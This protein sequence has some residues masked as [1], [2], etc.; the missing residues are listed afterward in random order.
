MAEMQD[1]MLADTILKLNKALFNVDSLEDFL[2]QIREPLRKAIF[3]DWSCFFLAGNFDSPPAMI[4]K[5]T[6]HFSWEKIHPMITAEDM[7]ASIL[8]RALPGEIFL[9]QNMTGTG[10]E[11][12][13]HTLELIYAKSGYRFSQH[14]ILAVINGFRLFMSMFRRDKPFNLDS[15]RALNL[16]VPTLTTCAQSLLSIR[17]SGSERILL[18]GLKITPDFK[19]ILLDNNLEATGLPE[20]TREFLIE[21]FHGPFVRELPELLRKWLDTFLKTDC[22]LKNKSEENTVFYSDEGSIVC[23]LNF[24]EDSSGSSKYL[25]VLEHQ[26]GTDD[27]THLEGLGLT[28][29]EVRILAN[30][31]AGKTNMQIGENLGIKEITVRKHLQNIG[32]K[33]HATGRAE[34]LAKA[35]EAREILPGRKSLSTT[36]KDLTFFKRIPEYSPDDDTCTRTIIDLSQK[37]NTLRNFDEIPELLKCVLAKHMSFDW[38]AVYCMTSSNEIEKI[39]VSPGLPFDW[40]KLYP[41]IRNFMSWIPAVRKGMTGEIFLTQDL[42]NPDN[43]QDLFTKTVMEAATGVFYSLIMPVAK[44]SG[45]RAFLGLYRNDSECPY[46]HDDVTV[47]DKLSPIIMLW[48]QNVLR[49][50]ESI[51]DYTGNSI[52]LERKHV[53]AMLFDEHLCDAMWTKDAM[54]LLI[55]QVGPYWR[56]D[57]L[58]S[59]RDWIKKKKLMQTGKKPSRQL[60]DPLVFN[61]YNLECHAYPLDSHILVKFTSR[62]QEPFLMLNKSGLTERQVQILSYLRLGYTNRQISA[63]LNIAEVTVK[64]HMER[65]GSKLEVHGRVAILCRAEEIR[66]SMV[67]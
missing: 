38:A 47:M 52:M 41:A 53:R 66:Q 55:S 56:R 11:G 14:V 64:K 28:R 39:I 8:F 35:I 50:M 25:A 12:D 37:I 58:P 63:A 20:S 61:K 59:L 34:I 2:E 60:N 6:P 62:M 65:I 21:H 23:T 32:G 31:Y 51:I 43:E 27:F 22:K 49:L 17:I 36:P 5:D 10:R 44:T 19:Y 4:T 42:I 16:L 45:H 54:E 15:V 48:A 7:N 57:L 30:L 29:Q 3:F 24:L 40:V 9:S 33:L 13:Q 18:S 1:H 26:R 46:T 67:R